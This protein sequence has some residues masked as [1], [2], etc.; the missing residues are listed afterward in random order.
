MSLQEKDSGYL[1]YNLNDM[2]HRFMFDQTYEVKIKALPY[3][4]SA[5]SRFTTKSGTGMYFFFF[6][7]FPVINILIPKNHENNTENLN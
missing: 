5:I 6:S 2:L 7:V 1:T 3:S 4:E